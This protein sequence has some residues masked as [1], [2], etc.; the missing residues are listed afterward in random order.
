MPRGERHPEPLLQVMPVELVVRRSC[1]TGPPPQPRA[2]LD[3]AG[4]T[5]IPA[6]PP[7]TH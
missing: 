2:S 1:G 6:L 4:L 5:T 3:V 7:R